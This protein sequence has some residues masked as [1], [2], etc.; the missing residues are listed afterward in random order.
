MHTVGEV[1]V[2]GAGRAVQGLGASGAP[3]AEG[4]TGGIVRADVRFRLD[5]APGGATVADAAHDDPP[6][7]PTRDLGRRSRVEPR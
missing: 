6:Q 5:D 2:G 3:R 1:H 7:K 4:V